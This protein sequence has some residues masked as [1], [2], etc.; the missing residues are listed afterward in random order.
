MTDLSNN[1]HS[2]TTGSIAEAQSSRRPIIGI[3]RAHPG[4]PRGRSKLPQVT[5]GT[6]D[7]HAPC[8]G[9][10]RAS[11]PR[12]RG[13]VDGRPGRQHSATSKTIDP[14]RGENS[15]AIRDSPY[16]QRSGP[17]AGSRLRKSLTP[18]PMALPV[19]P[20]PRRVPRPPGPAATPFVAR[21]AMGKQSLHQ[22][23]ILSR[24]PNHAY[25]DLADPCQTSRILASSTGYC[26][27]NLEYRVIFSR[28]VLIS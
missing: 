2:R 10:H 4:R 16:R 18:V 6:A 15:L 21:P 3:A 7:A 27:R 14:R 28:I 11:H 19:V 5:R 24:F 17:G 22:D 13:N 8:A 20:E 23:R 26:K 9:R 25:V 12:R 1:P